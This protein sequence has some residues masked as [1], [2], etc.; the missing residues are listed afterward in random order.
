MPLNWRESLMESVLSYKQERLLEILAYWFRANSTDGDCK[1][2]SGRHLVLPSVLAEA[3]NHSFYLVPS[4]VCLVKGVNM[5]PEPAH[6]IFRFWTKYERT[7]LISFI[8]SR[9]TTNCYLSTKWLVDLRSK[10]APVSGNRTSV[11]LTPASQETTVWLTII[12]SLVYW[13][14]CTYIYI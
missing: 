5:L 13:K 6:M 1:R 3:A 8:T 9:V 12:N 11:Y 7:V 2:F 10:P 4:F 14:T